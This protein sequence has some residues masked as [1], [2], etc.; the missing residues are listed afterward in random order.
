MPIT[1]VPSAGM[2]LWCNY[3]GTVAPEMTK[4]RRVLVVSSKP[5]NRRQSCVVVPFST[6]AP[7]PLAPWHHEIA[8][9]T[10]AFLPDRCW[11][12]ADM[13]GVVS[14]QRLDRLKV[15]GQWATPKVGIDDLR[16]V[17]RAVMAAMGVESTTAQAYLTSVT[18]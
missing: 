3:H 17:Q 12:K 2:V 18:P 13:V 1:F 11:A 5:A 16:A 10:Y 14:W 15:A 6:V 9:G 8:A 4:V 7:V